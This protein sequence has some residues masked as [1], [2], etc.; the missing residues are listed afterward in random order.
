MLT[1]PTHD[2]LITLGLTGMAKALEEQRKQ[3][4][5][6]TLAF[7][8]RLALLVDRE[9]TEREN[10]RLTTRL[11]FASLRQSACRRGYRYEDAARSRQGAVPPSSSPATGSTRHQNL[12]ITGPTGLAT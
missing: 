12:L 5:I 11:K 8:E 3:P 4:D 2:R 7:E 9:A 10:K 1:H 6:A